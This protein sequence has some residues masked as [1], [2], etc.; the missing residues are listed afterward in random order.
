M[1]GKNTALKNKIKDKRRSKAHGKSPMCFVYYENF[2]FTT[3]GLIIQVFSIPAEEKI[4][5]KASPPSIF[6]PWNS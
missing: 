1:A 2:I 3:D 5:R 4:Q 6:P